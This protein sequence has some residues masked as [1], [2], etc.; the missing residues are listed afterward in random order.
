MKLFTI[1]QTDPD[2][3][4]KKFWKKA[5]CHIYCI[6]YQPEL[7]YSRYMDNDYVFIHDI[8]RYRY[9]SKLTAREVC[10]FCKTG[11]NLLV[12]EA[13]HLEKGK[14]KHKRGKAPK[15]NQYCGCFFHIHCAKSN[16]LIF[17]SRCMRIL[18]S[19]C[20]VKCNCERS[21]PLLESDYYYLMCPYHLFQ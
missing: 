15:F 19:E 8:A 4:S 3:I 11:G 18:L 21:K 14:D 2:Y 1:Y 20:H 5:W 10:M 7:D 6:D 13:Q 16:R 17:S 12:C 9:R